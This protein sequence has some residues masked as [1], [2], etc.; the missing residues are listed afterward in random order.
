MGAAI[1]SAPTTFSEHV[2]K[3]LERVEHRV[4]SNPAERE[5]AFRLRYDA[6]R[7]IGF[8]MPRPDHK[9][10][11][12]LYDDD[13]M[14]WISM[15]FVDGELAGTVRVNVGTAENAVLPGLQVF[16]DVLAPRLRAR[17]TV[18]EFTRLAADISLSS[19]HPELPYVIMRPGFM[20]A[21]HLDA[22]FAVAMPREEHIVF[23]KRAFHAALWCAPR[24]YPG[25]TAK[26][27]C[28]GAEYRTV[29]AAIE[30]RYPFYQS[31]AAERVALFGARDLVPDRRSP[32]ARA[33]R[34]TGLGAEASSSA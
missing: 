5:A 16:S 2:L 8:L 4:A 33:P 29:R 9:L 27:A 22:D 12:P 20:A 19:V 18:V 23:Y 25:L 13:P 21:Q 34:L 24:N 3:F 6:Y 14:A 28:M 32:P 31:T 10:Y 15:S 11:D 7:R 26:L 17:R 30:A 1:S